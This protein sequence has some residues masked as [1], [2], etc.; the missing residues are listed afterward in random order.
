MTDI[1]HA[2]PLNHGV[3]QVL[4][5]YAE[6]IRVPLLG[7]RRLIFEVAAETEGVGPVEETLKWGQPAYLT[8]ETGAGSTIRFSATREGS[9]HDYAVHFICHTSLVEDFRQI[10]A[11]AL[12]FD[13]NRS[14]LFHSDQEMPEAELRQCIA[15]ALT[16]HL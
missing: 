12:T 7:I 2:P 3:E 5:S 13:G 11:T 14:I 4:A 6:A 1:E 15:M 16:Y 9:D 8:T 10:F